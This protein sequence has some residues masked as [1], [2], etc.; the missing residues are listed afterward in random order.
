MAAQRRHKR[1]VADLIGDHSDRMGEHYTRHVESEDN[2]TRAFNRIKNDKT[3]RE[4][5]SVA[6]L[7]N[8][9]GLSDNICA[10]SEKAMK[11]TMRTWRNW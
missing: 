2:I 8:A 9:K 11:S 1:E 4:Q 6:E 10:Q 3:G 7:Y 5:V